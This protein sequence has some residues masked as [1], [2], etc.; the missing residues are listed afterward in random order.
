VL[1]S[2]RKTDNEEQG[3]QSQAGS[4]PMSRCRS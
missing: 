3:H 1:L 4:P 2:N